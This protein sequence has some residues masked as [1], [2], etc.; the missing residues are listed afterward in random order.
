MESKILIIYIMHLMLLQHKF[1][2][3]IEKMLFK[4]MLVALDINDS[5]VLIFVI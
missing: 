2:I 3:L 4:V 1:G 5:N